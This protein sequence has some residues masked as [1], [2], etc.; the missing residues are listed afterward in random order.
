MLGPVA[1]LNALDAGVMKTQGAALSE[2]ER[3]SLA[4]FLGGAALPTAASMRPKFCDAT[5]A[6]FDFDDPPVLDGWGMTLEGS[7]YVDAAAAG[8]TAAQ[9]PRLALKWAFAFPGATRARSQPTEG[10]GALYVGSQDGTVYALDLATGCARWTFKASA[11]VRVSPTLEPWRRGDRSAR[12]MLWFADFSGNAYAVDAR[13]GHLIWK[14]RVGKHPMLTIT[15]SPR[16]YAGRLYVPMSSNEWA[17]AADPTYPCCTFRGGVVALDAA[18]GRVIWRSH[19]IPQ[20]PRATGQRNSAGAPRFAPAGAP[21]WNSPTI[22]VKRQRL[23]VGDG[24][25][26]TSPAAPQ[27]DS[28]IAYDLKTGRMIWWY[29]SIKHDAW[30]MACFI[31]G[32]PNC[33]REHGPDLDIGAPPILHR[34]PDGRD[35]LLVGEKSADVFALNPDDGKLLW[36]VKYG[37]GGFAG[38]VHWGMAASSSTLYAPNADTTFLGTEKGVPKPGLFALSPASGAIKWFA[39]APDACTAKTRPACDPGFSPPPTAIAGA[40]FQP[41]FDGWL[42][43]YRESDGQLIWSYDTTRDFHTVS[44][45]I[46]HGGSIE[47]AGAIVVHGVVAVNSGYLFG[48]RMG[49]NVLLVFSVD[50]R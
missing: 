9:V 32:G 47:S 35:E 34:L 2:S 25:A 12:P 16:Y 30:N 27:S 38:G 22:D 36:H 41:S 29:Q 14:R 11:E 49:G 6:A 15:G 24:E 7:R 21:V 3:R 43:A 46:A 45:V 42:R 20:R 37:R 8:I 4:E 28:V 33:P 44:G 17:S 50:G 31:G 39:K 18:T 26:Y 10:G 5:H 23:Y 19:T 48:G 13:S 1:I 40:V